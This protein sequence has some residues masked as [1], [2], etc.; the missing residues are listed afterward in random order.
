MIYSNALTVLTSDDET[1]ILRAFKA[2]DLF[3]SGRCVTAKFGSMRR[4]DCPGKSG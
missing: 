4:S 3:M 1:D 2:Q